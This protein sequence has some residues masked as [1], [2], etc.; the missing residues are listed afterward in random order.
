MLISDN[1]RP[2]EW[3]GHDHPRSIP[4][5]IYLIALFMTFHLCLL[6][7]LSSIRDCF[8]PVLVL[9]QKSPTL[10]FGH[11]KKK[12]LRLQT[13]KST[14]YTT[15]LEYCGYLFH[16]TGTARYPTFF[17]YYLH[18]PSGTNASLHVALSE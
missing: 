3:G 8:S 7:S 16:A 1:E 13:V 12:F 9:F 17:H 6:F 15:A 10:Y 5:N 14:E 11:G 4:S 18:F 2:L